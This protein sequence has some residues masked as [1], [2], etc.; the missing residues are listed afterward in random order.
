MNSVKN[1]SRFA[2]L[3]I[4]SD[5]SEDD[6]KPRTIK[7]QKVS[8]KNFGPYHVSN[9]NQ[10]KKKKRKAKPTKVQVDKETK[11]LVYKT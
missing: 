11:I 8:S 1:V 7:G 6:E 10:S 2:V 3:G 4:D 5:S 9:Q